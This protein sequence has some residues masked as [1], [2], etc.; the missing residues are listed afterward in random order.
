VTAHVEWMLGIALAGLSFALRS[1]AGGFTAMDP[2][3]LAPMQGAQGFASPARL[4]RAVA[5]AHLGS[6]LAAAASM[7]LLGSWVLPRFGWAGVLGALAAGAVVSYPVLEIF[8]ALY[9]SPRGGRRL[10]VGL[11]A[12]APVSWF[13]SGLRGALR[14]F[15]ERL[16]PGPG[17]N[18]SVVM[19]VRREAL[20][21][22]SDE[23]GE[24]RTLRQ[25][26]KQLV[27]QVYEFSESTVGEVMMPRNRMVGLSIDGTVGD[28]VRLAGEH[29]FSRYPLFRGTLDQIEG[30]LHI[31]DLLSAPGLDAPIGDFRRPIPFAPEAKKCDELLSELRR[32]HHHAAVVVDEF[33]GT[34]GWVT[35][36][37]LLEEL[38]GEIRDEHDVEEEVVRSVGRRA[39]MVDAG[40][41]VDELN[42]LLNLEIPEGDYETLAGYL[43]EE[44][45]RIPRKGERHEVDGARFTV[46]EVDPRR[47]LK[48][49]VER[50]D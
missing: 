45:Q 42:R 17:P 27:T 6:V 5:V 10:A 34:A 16:I 32:G 48:V 47:I 46:L 24:V 30:V 2:S 33:G 14:W 3:R 31:H 28:A 35:V 13:L 44:L 22:L 19:A 41:H 15:I 38:V 4:E 11:F 7:A 26:Q 50:V 43:L 25:A 23:R 12:Y 40:V 21:A 39:W 20:S 1:A 18:S 8:T 36:E 49:R 29:Q 37:D 9:M